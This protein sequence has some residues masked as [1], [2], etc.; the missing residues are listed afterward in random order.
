M[1]GRV[2]NVLVPLQ[3][4]FIIDALSSGGTDPK[5][6]YFCWL[7]ILLYS[8]LRFLQGGS[9]L[10]SSMQSYFWI[11]V[12]QWTTRKVTVDAFAHLHSLSLSWH[13]AKKSG[14]TLRVLDRGTSSI[15]SLLSYL[16]FN[17]VPTFVDIGVA[18]IFF[19][20]NFDWAF[21]VIGETFAER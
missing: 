8:S 10:L 5:T 3:Y 16:L 12:G 17:I 9:G 15:V 20:V 1:V 2:V 18:V 7:A 13:I 6:P 21:G 19:I 4:K 11:P 14:E